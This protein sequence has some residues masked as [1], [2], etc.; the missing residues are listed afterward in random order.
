MGISETKSKQQSPCSNCMHQPV[1]W[2]GNSCSRC[3]HKSLWG[4]CIGLWCHR[5]MHALTA[6]DLKFQ[7]CLGYT[8]TLSTLEKCKVAG[9]KVYLRWNQNSRAHAVTVC[10][11]LWCHGAMHAVC[12]CIGLWHHR[13]MHAL[14]AWDLKLQVCNGHTFTPAA[15]EK[16]KQFAGNSNLKCQY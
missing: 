8:F 10:I 14:T 9:V 6:W 5:L 1:M 4:A 12:T 3:M 7:V 13:L 2:W 16:C 11:S 15:L